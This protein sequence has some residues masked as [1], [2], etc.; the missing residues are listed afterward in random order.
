MSLPLFVE[1]INAAKVAARSKFVSEIGTQPVNEILTRVGYQSEVKITPDQLE[2]LIHYYKLGVVHRIKLKPAN[3]PK[4]YNH[5]L[6]TLA[7]DMPHVFKKNRH[8]EWTF[9]NFPL[10]EE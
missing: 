2:S 9:F 5:F 6:E 8:D 7:K 1:L 4:N 3:L 10:D